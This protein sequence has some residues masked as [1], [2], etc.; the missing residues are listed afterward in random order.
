MA[1]GDV[2]QNHDGQV[3]VDFGDRNSNFENRRADILIIDRLNPSK[4]LLVDVTMCEPMAKY[5]KSHD[6]AEQAA[7][8]AGDIKWKKYQQF[9]NIND[10]ADSRGLLYIAATTTKAAISKEFKKLIKHFISFYSNSE[11]LFK[12]QQAYQR[13]SCLIHKINCDNLSYAI[14]YFAK[15][16]N[17]S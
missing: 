17:T 10:D 3:Q 6:V 4:N 8:Q 2:S 1:A 5:I 11:Q 12:L 9:F 14:K 15:H 13:L 16:T 7:N